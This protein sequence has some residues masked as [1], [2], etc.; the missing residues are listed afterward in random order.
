MARSA[1]VVAIAALIVVPVRAGL[2]AVR[3]NEVLFM[4]DLFETSM[5]VAGAL[6]GRQF[7]G[8]WSRLGLYHPGPLWFYWAAPFQAAAGDQPAGLFLAALMLV[9][10]CSVATVLVVTRALGPM[11][12]LVAAV[13]VL[14]AIHQLSIAGLAYP[15]NPT[16]VILPVT[17]GMVCAAS[18]CSSGSYWTAGGAVVT[19]A[20]VAQAHLGGLVLGGALVVVGLLAPIAVR[21]RMG[22]RQRWG[23]WSVV[24]LLSLVPWIPVLYD[25]VAGVGNF[26]S[27][28]G[29]AVDGQVDERF[30]AV[31]SDNPGD[32]LSVAQVVPRVASMT[33]LVKSDVARW[34]GAEYLSGLQHRSMTSSVIVYLG[35]L[36]VAVLGSLLPR[37]RPSWEVPTFTVWLCRVSIGG[38]VIQMMAATRARGE[39][40]YYLI[41]GAAGTGV[42]LWMATALLVVAAAR[43]WAGRRFADGSRTVTPHAAVAGVVLVLLIGLGAPMQPFDGIPLRIDHDAPLIRTLL[44]AAPGDGFW[45]EPT[46]SGDLAASFALVASLD[47]HGRRVRVTGP[48]VAHFSDD[49]RSATEGRRIELV[50]PEE[51]LPDDCSEVGEMHGVVVCL[52]GDAVP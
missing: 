45:I 49:N 27:V 44:L 41:A 50:D 11:H 31:P 47:H 6:H 12:G 25:Q 1:L 48:Y 36:G 24:V 9:S 39:F 34:G 14:A 28:V 3:N 10:V 52:R 20:V 22:G 2:T 37:L 8:A 17:L 42:V 33:A 5:A 23:A 30:P 40:R 35:L 16:I 15:W 21:H 4:P 32:E 7:V 26:G 51:A 13:V 18:T 19:G 38:A 29:Y 46:K 43:A